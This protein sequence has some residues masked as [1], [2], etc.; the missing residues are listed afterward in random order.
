MEESNIWIIGVAALAIGALIGYL[1][2]RAGG[3]SGQQQLEDMQKELE[4]YKSKVAGHFEET[5]DLVNKMTESYRGVYQHLATGA[6]AL[7]DADTARSI[8]S[9]MTPQLALQKEVIIKEA[10]SESAEPNTEPKDTAKT[11]ASVNVEPPRDY[12]PK[13]AKEE[14]TLSESY[15]LKNAEAAADTESEKTSEKS[16]EKKA[17]PDDSAKKA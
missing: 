16:A 6:Q 13:Q 7:C 14:G 15:G 10:D 3:D 8:E 5:A 2:G 4:T 11:E 9:S 1:L 12:A 17:T